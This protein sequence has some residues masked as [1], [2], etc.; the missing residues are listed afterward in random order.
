MKGGTTVIFYLAVGVALTGNG[1]IAK[2][3]STNVSSLTEIA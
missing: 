2:F 3:V 1:A